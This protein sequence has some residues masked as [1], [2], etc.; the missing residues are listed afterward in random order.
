MRSRRRVATTPALPDCS[1]RPGGSSVAESAS[2]RLTR[3]ASAL[4]HAAAFAGRPTIPGD[5]WV[6]S[7]P[8]WARFLLSRDRLLLTRTLDLA[9]HARAAGVGIPLPRS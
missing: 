8:R 7:L 3:R 9:L 4:V 2:I 6:L 1:P 5:Q